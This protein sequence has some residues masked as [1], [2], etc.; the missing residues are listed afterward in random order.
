MAN[1]DSRL[2][3]ALRGLARGSWSYNSV[4]NRYILTGMFFRICMVT[5]VLI[6]LLCLDYATDL[7][8]PSAWGDSLL[9]PS[10]GGPRAAEAWGRLGVEHRPGIG[11]FPCEL[12]HG[13]V[14]SSVI[15]GGIESSCTGNAFVRFAIGFLEGLALYAPVSLF[16]RL[17]TALANKHSVSQVHF[18][19]VLLSR[20]R[21][22][23]NP[24]I[25]RTHLLALC[26]SSTFLGAFISSFYAAV[27]F[28]RTAVIAR[29]FPHISHNFW[30]G[31]FGC[32]MA[33]CLT[34][35]WSIFIEEQRRRGEMALYVLPRALRTLVKDSWLR[36]GSKTVQT[37]ERCVPSC[38]RTETRTY[39]HT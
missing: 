39:S 30:D 19:P 8:Y 27:C 12:V 18:L 22:L 13:R 24:S 23:L 5:S 32:I 16:F 3:E 7:G 10:Q 11:G 21:T 20:P 36:S 17:G 37:L 25:L 29:L 31:P 35:G 4:E 28:T 38:Q 9:I 14:G 1:V 15:P 26:R 2:L 34:C 6:S 33:G